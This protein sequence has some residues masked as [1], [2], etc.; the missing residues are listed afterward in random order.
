[1]NHL[2]ATTGTALTV[3]GSWA[4][5]TTELANLTMLRTHQ[6]TDPPTHAYGRASAS[7]T[8]HK[9]GKHCLSS[10]TVMHFFTC[11]SV[12]SALGDGVVRRDTGGEGINADLPTPPTP[13]LPFPVTTWTGCEKLPLA[14]FLLL[15]LLLLLVFLDV[16]I[17]SLS[18][19]DDDDDV[20]D[21][22]VDES[23][24]VFG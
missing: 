9:K 2:L 6:Q 17:S 8:T 24:R 12:I 15:L 22:D 11:A 4:G 10:N 21:D 13:P 7:K 5:G 3:V 19:L 18:T 16:V 1:M 20:V 23:L 14:L